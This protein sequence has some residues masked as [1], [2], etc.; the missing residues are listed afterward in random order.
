MPSFLHETTEK[1]TLLLHCAVNCLAVGVR[2]FVYLSQPFVACVQALQRASNIGAAAY[3]SPAGIDV[4]ASSQPP[5]SCPCRAIWRQALTGDAGV[6]TRCGGNEANA[7]ACQTGA[8]TPVGRLGAVPCQ[9]CAR[10]RGSHSVHLFCMLTSR[11][12]LRMNAPGTTRQAHRCAKL[13]EPVST[14]GL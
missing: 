6:P 7:N 3:V 9:S 1:P 14:R 2:R 4:N 8:A 11:C 13:K 5:L 12:V 10:W